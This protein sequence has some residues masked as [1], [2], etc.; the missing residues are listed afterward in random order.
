MVT[1]YATFTEIIDNAQDRT[2][3]SNV[4]SVCDIV[5]FIIGYVAVSALLK[6]I[7]IRIVALILLPLVLTML[8][9]L[10]KIK[11]KSTLGDEKLDF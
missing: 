6:G 3:L 5:Y 11:E 9:P 1:Y 2:F 4:K 8:I 10:F 7:N